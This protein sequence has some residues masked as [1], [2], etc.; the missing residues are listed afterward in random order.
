[1][2]R[3]YVATGEPFDKAGGY[4]IQVKDV[5]NQMSNAPNDVKGVLHSELFQ[6]CGCTLVKGISGDYFNVMGFPAHRFKKSKIG[7]TF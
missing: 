1:M 3:A 6:A 2:I 7:F 5:F 4:G